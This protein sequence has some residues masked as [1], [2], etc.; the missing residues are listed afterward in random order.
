MQPNRTIIHKKAED[1]YNKGI[2]L[3]RFELKYNF[4]NRK[5]I[6]KKVFVE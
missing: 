6:H 4:K 5:L 1:K 3:A 2:S